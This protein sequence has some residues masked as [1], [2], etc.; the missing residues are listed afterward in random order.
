MFSV[1]EIKLHK[2]DAL[3]IAWGFNYNKAIDMFDSKRENIQLR[4]S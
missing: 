1:E 2:Y 4:I 3:S